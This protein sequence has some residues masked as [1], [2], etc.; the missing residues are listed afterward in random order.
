MIKFMG[1][2]RYEKTIRN[3]PGRNYECIYCGLKKNDTRGSIT[4]GFDTI[5]LS[6]IEDR[7]SVV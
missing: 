3:L 1:T 5:P 4:Y 6:F 7:K 2:H